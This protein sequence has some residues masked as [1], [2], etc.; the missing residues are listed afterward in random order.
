V[1]LIVDSELELGIVAINEERVTGTSGLDGS[2]AVG[3]I[4]GLLV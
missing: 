4:V 1:W 2:V 3:V